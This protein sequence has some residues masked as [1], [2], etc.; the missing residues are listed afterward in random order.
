MIF[1]LDMSEKWIDLGNNQAV[2]VDYPTSEQKY[3]LRLLQ[4]KGIDF[5]IEKDEEGIKFDTMTL[6]QYAK[7]DAASKLFAEYYLKYVIKEFRNIK[8][9]L[10]V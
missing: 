9:S 5:A 6:E 1:T 8:T 4:T 3:K 7:L 2:R 10:G